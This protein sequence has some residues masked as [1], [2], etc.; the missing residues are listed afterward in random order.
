MPF[1][2]RNT[3]NVGIVEFNEYVGVGNTYVGVGGR[4]FAPLMKKP[5]HTWKADPAL[6]VLSP[7][8]AFAPPNHKERYI[9]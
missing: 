7:G 4:R 2:P 5:G 9:G 8:A 6:M 1:I 3:D